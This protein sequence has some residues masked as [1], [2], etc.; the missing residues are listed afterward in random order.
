MQL[1]LDTFN[2]VNGTALA[3]H[4]PVVGGPWTDNDA[5]LQIMNNKLVGS[6]ANDDSTAPIFSKTL[7]VQ[8]AFNMNLAED[9]S[10]IILG[11]YRD[12]V[13]DTGVEFRVK[14]TGDVGFD[15]YNGGGHSYNGLVQ[16][17]DP[18]IDHLAVLLV[19]AGYASLA[20]DGRLLFRCPRFLLP[21]TFFTLV[22]LTMKVAAGASPNISRLLVGR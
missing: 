8:F 13:F 16:F 9:A 5:G 1:L 19:A 4:T 7:S 2:G 21:S 10:Q 18:A 11:F 12:D 6:G 14:G 17:F 22:D 3:A 20:L 15:I